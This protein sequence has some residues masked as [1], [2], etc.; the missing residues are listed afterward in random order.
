MCYSKPVSTLIVAIHNSDSM[1]Q[2]LE[3]LIDHKT[4][5][6]F[7]TS[8]SFNFHPKDLQDLTDKLPSPFILMGY[9][10][11]GMRGGKY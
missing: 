11:L 10:S 3:V 8:Y 2:H 5:Y 1:S 9:F 7:T 4:N 6:L